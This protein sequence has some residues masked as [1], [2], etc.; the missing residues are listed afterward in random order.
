MQSLRQQVQQ[1]LEETSTVPR[2]LDTWRRARTGE[3]GGHEDSS[4]PVRRRLHVS[5]ADLMGKQAREIR[6]RAA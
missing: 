2:L 4:G 1:D 3:G 5:M 6:G